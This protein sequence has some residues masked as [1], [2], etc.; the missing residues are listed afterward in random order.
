MAEAINIPKEELMM[1]SSDTKI[2]PDTFDEMGV[3]AEG[4]V[5][6]GNIKTKGHLAILGEV[7]GNVEAKGNVILTGKVNGKVVCTNLLVDSKETCT[8]IKAHGQVQIKSN[9]TVKGNVTCKDFSLFGVL[10]GNLKA[11]NQACF[12]AGSRMNGDVNTKDLGVEIGA[13]ITGPI[14]MK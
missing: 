11:S 4:T 9:S 7:N 10:T 12:F 6:K 13:K 1:N 5:I 3:I 2:V 14:Q 8:T